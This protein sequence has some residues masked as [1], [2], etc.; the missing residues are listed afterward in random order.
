MFLFYK[1]LWPG[2][3]PRTP[4]RHPARHKQAA[5]RGPPPRSGAEPSLPAGSLV[6][7]RPEGEGPGVRKRARPRTRSSPSDCGVA[8]SPARTSAAAPTAWDR[9]AQALGAQQLPPFRRCAR[10]E[11]RSAHRHPT[12]FAQAY[13]GLTHVAGGAQTI[14]KALPRVRGR[15]CGPPRGDNPGNPS[16]TPAT[17]CCR[18]D[19]PARSTRFDVLV[20]DQGEE[21][22]GA[23]E[24]SLAPDR[25]GIHPVRLMET[26][27][28]AVWIGGPICRGR[29]RRD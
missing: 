26:A 16:T 23:H 11:R 15:R 12:S 9:E 3:T 25:D 5:R 14:G 8:P 10:P 13:T 24:Y 28:P 7:E 19:G 20:Q 22:T 1:N 6:W 2:E 17:R 18:G 29:R 21:G 4:E 27:T